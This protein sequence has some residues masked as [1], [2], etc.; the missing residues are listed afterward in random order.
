MSERQGTRHGSRVEGAVASHRVNDRCTPKDVPRE[1]GSLRVEVQDV[2][3]RY[4][5]VTGHRD[6]RDST[7]SRS[8]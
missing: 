5:A 8:P 6:A 2:E 1:R 7:A 3:T 4:L